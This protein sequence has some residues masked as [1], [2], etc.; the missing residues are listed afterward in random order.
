[1]HARMDRVRPGDAERDAIV[2]ALAEALQAR[3]EIVL[4][5]LHGSLARGATHIGD[6]DVAVLLE[7]QPTRDE[8][9]DAELAIEQALD[10]A[11]EP[12]VEVRVL[13]HAPLAFRFAVLR[14]GRT[15]LTRSEQ[16]KDAFECG[17]LALYHDFSYHLSAYRRES[18][19]L[20]S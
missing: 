8:A 12:R 1:M 18:L 3:E 13:N 4:A 16:A 15:L 7:G 5:Y 10:Q 9:L 19:G 14:D 11:V 2:A 20:G 17:T 6:V